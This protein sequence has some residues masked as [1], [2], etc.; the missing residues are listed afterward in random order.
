MS[1]DIAKYLPLLLVIPLVLWRMQRMSRKQPL[2][3]N[4][5]WIRPAS[6]LVVCVMVIVLPQVLHPRGMPVHGFG[7]MDLLAIAVAI[8]LGAVAG[9]YM[10]RTM[11]I[12]VHPEEGTLM[13][14]A[15]PIGL[16]VILGLVVLRLG[17]RAGAGYEAQAWHLNVGLIFEGLIVFSAALFTVRSLEMYLRAKKLMRDH[18]GAAFS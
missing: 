6:V 10:G 17:L 11:K 16:L 1:P 12:D 5:L 18:L 3:L 9:W 15:S 8:P 7:M 14:Q 4:R 13:V 2:K